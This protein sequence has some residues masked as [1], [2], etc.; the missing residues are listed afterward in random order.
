MSDQ[1]SDPLK[2]RIR[3]A[4]A[5]YALRPEDPP[6]FFHVG[7]YWRLLATSV[8]T[9]GRSCT[10]DELC[11]HGVVAPPHVHD[12]EEEAFFVL[13]GDLVFTLNDEEI[14]APPG[15]FVY[16][17]PGTTHSFR[18]TS[19]FGRVYNYLV[20]GGFDHG[21]YAGGTPAPPVEM[22]PPGVSAAQAW[23]F[24]DQHRPRAPWEG[25]REDDERR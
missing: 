17:I 1:H 25:A 21:V 14:P 5:G 18:C 13:E 19:A 2:A 11:P 12:T 7:T 23:R 4:A 16:I 8:S 24:L 3:S 9:Q 22:P 10:F 6:A 20:P 15:T